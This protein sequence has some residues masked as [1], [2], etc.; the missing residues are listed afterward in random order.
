MRCVPD[1][2]AFE[3]LARPGT[4]IPVYREILADLETPVSVYLKL[5]QDAQHA[6][7]LESVEGGEEAAHYSFVGAR[8]ASVA[9]FEY[10][11]DGV[12]QERDGGY[13]T[14]HTED[15]LSAI[16]KLC[17]EREVVMGE[18]NLPRFIGGAL[19]FIGYECIQL[20]EPRL[21]ERT[22]RNLAAE[23]SIEC[24]AAV[25]LMVDT[26]VIFDHLRNRVLLLTHALVDDD[27]LEAYRVALD[28]IEDLAARLAGPLPELPADVTGIDIDHVIPPTHS[29]TTYDEF[30]AS[31][32]TIKEHIVAGDVIQTVV[33]QRW[34]RPTAATDLDIYRALRMVNPS[35]YM[36]L[37]K[38]GDMSLVGASPELL[39]HVAGDTVATHPIAGTRPRAETA[40]EDAAL[41]ASLRADPKERAEHIML[42]DLGRNDIGRVSA[43]GTVRVTKLMNVERFSHVM[44]LTSHVEGTLDANTGAVDAVR[45]C[46]PAGTV[47]GAPKVRAM[48]IIADLEPD[49][50]G[51]YAGAL[52]YLSVDGN[53]DMAITIRTMLLRDGIAHV[54]A[55]AGIVYDSIPDTEFEESR[56]K[57]KAMFRAIDVAEEVIARATIRDGSRS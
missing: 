7:L 45:A 6:F 30:V 22:A 27:P 31:V 23:T 38:L 1:I 15:P 10:G 33:S 25:M 11:K 35:P 19:G 51:P 47:A 32:E 3:Q 28:R 34:S 29:N 2:E 43:P 14:L 16:A 5:A 50:R 53:L 54:Q 57:A 26:L 39:V 17:S 40:A 37:L 36:Y 49:A 8:P 41:E 52:G 44:H 4:L 13:Q 55:G 12:L 18:A 46:F 56:S 20:W 9:T 48:E 21:A 24:P 42:V